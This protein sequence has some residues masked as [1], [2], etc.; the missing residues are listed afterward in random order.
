LL[1]E[2]K[3]QKD[4]L[5]PKDHLFSRNCTPAIL[6]TQEAEMGRLSG[7]AVISY[8]VQLFTG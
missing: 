1:E 7:V 3:T 5:T 4:E 2:K 6:V 8:H